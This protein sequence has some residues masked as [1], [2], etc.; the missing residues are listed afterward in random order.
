M[1]QS[2]FLRRIQSDRVTLP[3]TLICA[4]TR[5]TLAEEIWKLCAEFPTSRARQDPLFD[6][7]AK[8]PVLSSF[9]KRILTTPFHT[10]HFMMA[11]R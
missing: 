9:W 10:C 3:S 4:L 11:R 6:A 2:T 1:R 8:V 7:E 5:L